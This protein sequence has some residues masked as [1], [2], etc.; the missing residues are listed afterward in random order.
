M[1][2][3]SKDHKDVELAALEIGPLIR[4]LALLVSNKAA[5]SEIFVFEDEDEN[6]AELLRDAWYNIAAHGF[7][8]RTALGQQ[9]SEEL[10]L[11]AEHTSP[12]VSEDR[13]EQMESDIELNTILRRGMTSHNT[14]DLKRDLIVALPAREAEIR[15]LS[16]PKLL[17][18]SAV[19]LIETLRASTGDCSKVLTYFNEP[20]LRGAEMSSCMQS[21]NDEVVRIY[22]TKALSGQYASFS[23][24]HIAKQLATIFTFCCHRIQRVQTAAT[25]TADRIIAQAPSSLCH[26]SSLFALLE[27]IS[28]MWSS[29]LESETDE[30]EWTSTFTST[31][32]KITLQLSDSFAFRKYTLDAFYKQAKAWTAG[33]MSL[34]PLDIK[35]LLQ[36][37]LSEMND[38]GAY[39]HVSLGRSFALEMGSL[40]PAS[41]QRLGAINRHG[42]SNINVASDFIAQYTTRQEYRY[43]ET[44]AHHGQQ[45]LA[46]MDLNG[47]RDV[48]GGRPPQILEDTERVVADLEHRISNGKD[49]S[50][51]E[52]QNVLRRAASLLCR[53]KQSLSAVV[54]HLVSIPFEAFTKQSI[55]LGISLWLGVIHENPRMES[56]I[57]TEVAEAWEN[58]IHRREGLFSEAFK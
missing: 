54:H 20:A 17:F 48:V 8:P 7:S 40:I 55:K 30:Y 15:R 41:D 5:A 4:P 39:G 14:D 24:H 34:A 2:K 26:K 58:T 49:V 51:G 25:L 18:L 28:I 31:R 37:Y 9:Y 50:I 27:L 11:L 10:R 43:A 42:D 21:I 45:W 47:D 6:I 13:A 1:G 44:I 19:H 29:C 38:D 32:G 57:L 22:L 56:R 52:M 23:A 3:S 33:V 12:L 46:F 16:Y 35:G 36:T 53:S